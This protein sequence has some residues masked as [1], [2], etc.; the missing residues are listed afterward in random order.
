MS[1]LKKVDVFVY[2][3][4]LD[5]PVITSFGIM[6]NR[7]LLLLKVTD[8]NGIEGWGEIWCNFPLTG[9]EHRAKLVDNVF[10][11]LLTNHVISSPKETFA[12]L[13]NK[14]K[15]LSI[16]SGEPGPI[17]QCIAG[18]DIAL[19]DLIAKKE[20]VP[21]W[22]KFGGKKKTIPIYASGINPTNPSLIVEK[23]LKD[24]FKAFKL[25]IGF[26][27]EKDLENIKEINNIIP[28]NYSLMVD[29]NQAWNLEEAI[30]NCN[31]LE[32]FDLNWVEEPIPA[33]SSLKDWKLLSEKTNIPLAAGE[34]FSGHEEF[35]KYFRNKVFKYLQPDIA[36]WGGFSECI[37]LVKKIKKNRV[38]YCPHFLGGGIGLIASAHLLSASNDN[39]ILEVDVNKNP[40]RSEIIS[41]MLIQDKGC[42]ELSDKPGL[43]CEPNLK[44]INKYLV[45][46]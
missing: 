10:S 13:T 9:A 7:P 40:L 33:D 42:L 36:K 23:A 32:K 34:N 44:S 4:P 31:K 14:T 25:K 43:G 28:K 20:K 3:Y 30:K 27:I 38:T 6:N 29:A 26:G 18:I 19:H 15:I 11:P 17:A 46:H 45:A 16:Q 21:L 41:D 1:I 37:T 5:N 24:N 39:G 8:N 22:K 12:F 35:S 2:R